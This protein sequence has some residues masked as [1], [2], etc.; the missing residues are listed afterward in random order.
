MRE[1]WPDSRPGGRPLGGCPLGEGP[2][3][4]LTLGATGSSETQLLWVYLAH[5]QTRAV[6]KQHFTL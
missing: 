2:G 3:W 5:P 6:G 1:A 4:N